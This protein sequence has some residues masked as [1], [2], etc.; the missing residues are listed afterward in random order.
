MKNSLTN[1]LKI[2]TNKILNTNKKN[3]FVIDI[4]LLLIILCPYFLILLGNHGLLETDEGR[5]NEVAWGMLQ[6]KQYIIPKMN[7]VV[8]FDKPILYYWLQ[9]LS[10]KIFGFSEWSARFF[11]ALMGVATSLGLYVFG[12][13]LFTRTIG[14][15]AALI[16]PTMIYWFSLSH[17]SNMDIEVASW[18]SLSLLS[19]ITG[20]NHYTKNKRFAAL[21]F[22]YLFASF[23]FLTKGLMAIAFPV[24]IIGLWVIIDNKWSMIKHMK[25]I[26][27][28]ILCIIICCPWFFIVQLKY[29]EFLQYFFIDQQIDRFLSKSM[30]EQQD[31]FFYIYMTLVGSLPWVF[32]IIQAFLIPFGK[33][34]KLPD[35]QRSTSKL[36]LIWATVIL[37]FFSIPA[38]KPLGYI[39]PIFPPIALLIS[40]FISNIDNTKTKIKTKFNSKHF[41]TSN[42]ALIIYLLITALIFFIVYLFNLSHKNPLIYPNIL[43]QAVITIIICAFYIYAY[44]TKNIKHVITILVIYG[45][46][47]NINILNI[48]PKLPVN[49]VKIFAQR[50]KKHIQSNDIVAMI[51][52]N[53]GMPLYL[54]RKIVVIANWLS[55]EMKAADGYAQIFNFGLEHHPN[56]YPWLLTPNQFWKKFNNPKIN[57]IL[58]MDKNSVKS[59]LKKH[60]KSCLIITGKERAAIK[61]NCIDK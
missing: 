60:K 37:I 12:S 52:Y 38:S 31:W 5:Y 23:A 3:S 35:N 11:P 30:N 42:Y 16:L 59:F 20:I 24:I 56:S 36:L 41:K 6:N 54:N 18:I 13:K 9:I 15:V 17:Y 49:S 8:F 10:F 58:I 48:I 53:R 47:F 27:G 51:G 19:F 39:A 50:L 45:V 28:L 40:L 57:I 44:K 22:A 33:I 46:L 55:P 2:D 32:F 25:I 34:I 4:I 29:P 14:F 61:N 26:P 43:I 1:T 21:F 7:G